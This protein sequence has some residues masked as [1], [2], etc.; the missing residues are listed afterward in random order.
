MI[1]DEIQQFQNGFNNFYG[2]MSKVNNRFLATSI[3]E[4]RKDMSFIQERGEE[5]KK[6]EKRKEEKGKEGLGVCF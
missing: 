5:K 1:S 4:G 3:R 2:F 6:E